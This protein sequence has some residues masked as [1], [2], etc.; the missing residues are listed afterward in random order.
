MLPWCTTSV[1]GWLLMLTLWGTF[2]ALSVWA[3]SWL[4][5]VNR[6]AGQAAGRLSGNPEHLAEVSWRSPSVSGP[7]S[8][9]NMT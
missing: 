6:D 2:I 3:I 9:M 7:V 4:I 1:A 8:P 5:P